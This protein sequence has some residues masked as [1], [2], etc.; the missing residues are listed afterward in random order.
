M[1][2]TNITP[3][4]AKRLCDLIGIGHEIAADSNGDIVYAD[5]K[6]GDALDILGLHSKLVWHG[7]P[8]KWQVEPV[9]A[10]L[11]DWADALERLNG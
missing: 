9:V 10:M 8:A 11:R 6:L 2:T 1:T 5:T 7:T 3:H 4:Q